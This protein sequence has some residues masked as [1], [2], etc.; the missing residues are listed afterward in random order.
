MFYRTFNEINQ[1]LLTS[2]SDTTAQQNVINKSLLE[3]KL[4]FSTKEY[5]LDYASTGSQVYLDADVRWKYLPPLLNHQLFIRTID[6]SKC[7]RK[8]SGSS[9]SFQ[10]EETVIIMVLIDKRCKNIPGWIRAN[11][12]LKV[13][14][15][16]I[17]HDGDAEEEIIYDIYGKL[18][19]ASVPVSIGS[20]GTDLMLRS[21]SLCVLPQTSSIRGQVEFREEAILEVNFPLSSI[22]HAYC[23]MLAVYCT[24]FL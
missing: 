1:A 4:S 10:V 18:L 7:K 22:F 8:I 16:C 11:K 14:G 17:A 23:L 13:F 24:Y 19:P 5:L 20:C 3:A 15:Q 9:L 6:G 21:V 2:V 12:F